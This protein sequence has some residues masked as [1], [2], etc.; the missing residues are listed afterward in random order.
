M[1]TP[2]LADTGKAA[3]LP[4]WKQPETLELARSFAWPVGIALFAG[5][6]LLGLVRPAIKALAPQPVVEGGPQFDALEADVLDR[7]ALAPPKPGDPAPEQLRLEEARALA[8]QNPI[9]VA[10]IVKAWVNGE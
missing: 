6:V 8:R 5:L 1:N 2:F 10:N 4:L 9:A 7:P 3:D